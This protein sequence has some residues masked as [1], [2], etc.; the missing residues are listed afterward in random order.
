M[1][2]KGVWREEVAQEV[3]FLVATQLPRAK[4]SMLQESSLSFRGV[5]K[6]EDWDRTH[7]EL[8]FIPSK[9]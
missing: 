5:K 8:T 4:T 2:G 9:E 7:S 3:V 1:P 6:R